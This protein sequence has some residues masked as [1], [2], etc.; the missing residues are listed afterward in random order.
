MQMDCLLMKKSYIW[1]KYVTFPKNIG[2]LIQLHEKISPRQL[3]EQEVSMHL[4]A[5][6]IQDTGLQLKAMKTINT[7]NFMVANGWVSKLS[8]IRLT[9]G[10]VVFKANVRHSMSFNS[11]KDLCTWVA[12]HED[13]TIMA[14]HCNCTIG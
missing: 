11:K 8:A 5:R 7:A 9:H 6:R 10:A 14:A 3:T 12:V 2:F 13:S 4:I 1:I